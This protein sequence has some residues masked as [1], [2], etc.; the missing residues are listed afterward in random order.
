[1][2]LRYFGREVNILAKLSHPDIP[3]IC[4]Y[5]AKMDR[6]PGRIA[7]ASARIAE[8][9][10]YSDDQWQTSRVR[11]MID[12]ALAENKKPCIV[13]RSLSVLL[14]SGTTGFEPSLAIQSSSSNP[15]CAERFNP[16][17]DS[18]SG[19]IRLLPGSFQPSSSR[20]PFGVH[21][22][23]QEDCGD[24]QGNHRLLDRSRRLAH[25][26]RSSAHS[27]RKWNGCGLWPPQAFGKAAHKPPKVVISKMT[28]TVKLGL[29]GLLRRSRNL[30]HPDCARR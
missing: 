18:G 2:T 16:T 24:R 10:R 13:V 11:S 22:S 30:D 26:F 7:H 3:K 12:P 29:C 15:I 6:Y 21:G 27:L 1:M 14:T 28:I 9:E 4:G 17:S 23:T 5:F 19:Q 25:L 8:A 20:N